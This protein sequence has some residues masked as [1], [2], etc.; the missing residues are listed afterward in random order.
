VTPE[1]VEELHHLLA[2][3][4]EAFAGG[5]TAGIVR[6]DIRFH[7]R[8]TAAA[9]NPDLAR[10]LDPI[11]GRATIAMLAGDLQSWPAK[12]LPEHE[13]IMH[14]IAAGDGEA[15]RRH[16]EDHVLKVRDRLSSK[17][18]RGPEPPVPS[19]A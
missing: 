2:A 6:A 12:A 9:A 8:I 17:L 5:D 4:R 7:A 1:L 18:V 16:G 10:V 14:A 11:H 19:L 13:A 3:Q 15:A